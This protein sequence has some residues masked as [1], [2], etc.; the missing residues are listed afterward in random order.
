M[1]D[2]NHDFERDFWGDCVNTYDED[3]KHYIYAK[4]MGLGQSHYTLTVP[5]GV[6]KI[7]DIG[8]GP[9]SMILKTG[10]KTADCLVVDPLAGGYPEWVHKRYECR[11]VKCMQGQG[12]DISN[13]PDTYHEA[14]MYNV[15]QHTE[16]PEL[17]VRNL[18]TLAPTVRIFEWI[19][20]PA[21]EG[22]PHMLTEEM[23]NRAVGQRGT[24]GYLDGTNGCQ[25]RFWA[26]HWVSGAAA[27]T[28]QL[29]KLI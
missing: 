16:D 19:D 5:S 23:L 26:T 6:S 25:G 15:L 8:G 11:G 13:I 18:K 14:W 20:I 12:E 28:C 21:H 3:Q 24:T 4:Y 2:H 17:I 22:H 9:S 10:V 29:K 1:G 7:I 27:A